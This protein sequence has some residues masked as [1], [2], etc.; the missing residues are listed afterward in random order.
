MLPDPVTSGTQPTTGQHTLPC[1]DVDRAVFRI[2]HYALIGPENKERALRE[3]CAVAYLL[4]PS[5]FQSELMHVEVECSSRYASDATPPP[6]CA[7]QPRPAHAAC[8]PNV[9][10]RLRTA[11]ATHHAGASPRLSPACKTINRDPGRQG[12]PA[13]RTFACSRICVLV[14][15][16]GIRW[17]LG[18]P[19]APPSAG[20]LQVVR[21]ANKLRHLPHVE[22]DEERDRRQGGG[23]PV[24]VGQGV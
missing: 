19:L 6:A 12:K 9:A 2:L 10:R 16:H 23:R 15:P 18:A 17:H 7:P 14:Y 4:D 22:E 20:L 8:T 13:L 21:G 24:G 11:Q 3:P 1:R 5:R